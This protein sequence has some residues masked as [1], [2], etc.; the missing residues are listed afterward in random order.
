M[1]HVAVRLVPSVLT[2]D[3]VAVPTATAVIKPNE[4]TVAMDVW[5]DDHVNVLLVAF[6]GT[7]AADNRTVA[8]GTNVV[9]LGINDKLDMI[10][11]LADTETETVL[12]TFDPSVA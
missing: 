9:D 3:I 12:Y 1:E 8:P 10:M 11:G 4:F 2:A 6:D 5:L 7:I